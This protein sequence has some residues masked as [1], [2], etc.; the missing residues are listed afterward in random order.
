M[1]N[2]KL[3]GLKREILERAQRVQKELGTNATA[4]KYAAEL[5]FQLLELG[6]EQ[7]WK[8]LKTC[9]FKKILV[10]RKLVVC[11]K[12]KKEGITGAD[13]ERIKRDIREKGYKTA[14]LLDFW[15]PGV[16]DSAIEVK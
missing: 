13:K 6:H 7:E 8:P 5:W 16:K 3:N 15:A 14:L 4:F 10:A 12:W 1:E 11:L 2:I 9:T